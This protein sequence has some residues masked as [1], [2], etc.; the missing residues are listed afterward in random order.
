[1]KII[2][3]RKVFRRTISIRDSQVKAALKKNEPVRIVYGNWFMDLSV[4]D[5]KKGIISLKQRFRTKFGRESEPYALVDY[6]W[7]P[8]GSLY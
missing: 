5:L 7:K 6:E 3:V 4:E 1:M 2:K 8:S